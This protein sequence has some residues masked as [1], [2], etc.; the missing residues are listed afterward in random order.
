MRSVKAVAE[1]GRKQ[2]AQRVE[3]I[4]RVENTEVL[5]PGYPILLFDSASVVACQ[6]FVHQNA[7]SMVR[8]Q[9]QAEKLTLLVAKNTTGY[10]GV[11]LGKPGQPKPYQAQVWRGGKMVYL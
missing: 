8:L 10:F 11:H 4:Y 2:R 1:C 9:A 5:T 6:T 3:G 7:Q